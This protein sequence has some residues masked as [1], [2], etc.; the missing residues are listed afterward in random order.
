MLMK[1]MNV[2]ETV[3]L[4]SGRSRKKL[5]LSRG[6]NNSENSETQVSHRGTSRTKHRDMATDSV[7]SSSP[8]LRSFRRTM[9]QAEDSTSLKEEETVERSLLLAQDK[10]KYKRGSQEPSSESGNDDSVIL[11]TAKQ[12][13]HGRASRVC[14]DH[15][16][17]S[18][19]AQQRI[20][21]QAHEEVI[22]SMR[23]M[24]PCEPDE[25]DEGFEDH[26]MGALTLLMSVQPGSQGTS[27][28]TLPPKSPHRDSSHRMSKEDAVMPATIGIGIITHM[29]DVHLANSHI[30]EDHSRGMSTLSINIVV[31]P[32]VRQLPGLPT[33]MEDLNIAGA[34]T[35]LAA[36]RQTGETTQMYEQR[37]AGTKDPQLLPFLDRQKNVLSKGRS[38]SL[39]L[40]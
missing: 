36:P 2:D 40:K 28:P 27:P 16:I 21:L 5:F 15:G 37:L 39:C 10:G 17:K 18:P 30:R 22:A 1:V 9:N 38:R 32:E 19:R 6:G 3:L 34:I 33:I 29:Q 8:A 20:Y 14:E 35:G 26:F 12:K 13:L 24:G 7:K 23:V 11:L 31:P 25:E 4:S